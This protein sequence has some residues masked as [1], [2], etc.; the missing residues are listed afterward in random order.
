MVDL[1]KSTHAQLHVEDR[2][3]WPRRQGFDFNFQTHVVPLQDG[4]IA[5]MCY[6]EGYVLEGDGILPWKES[7]R[8]AG[9]LAP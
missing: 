9:L 2:A 1:R 6:D 8:I 5:I 7:G 4:R 3:F